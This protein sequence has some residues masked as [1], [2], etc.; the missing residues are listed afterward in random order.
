VVELNSGMV[1]KSVLIIM[2][3]EYCGWSSRKEL[4][5]NNTII[6]LHWVPCLLS[7]SERDV[8]KV[9]TLS[10]RSSILVYIFSSDWVGV[11]HFLLFLNPMLVCPPFRA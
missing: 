10:K 4:V 2:L 7:F 11:I 9:D 1:G 3:H 6:M 8:V 5:C